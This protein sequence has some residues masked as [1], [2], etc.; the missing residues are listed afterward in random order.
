MFLQL[1][2]EIK[3]E[4]YE[5]NINTHIEN[6]KSFVRPIIRHLKTISK[7]SKQVKLN[8]RQDDKQSK[9]NGSS[10]RD[11]ADLSWTKLEKDQNTACQESTY[12]KS[13]IF[14]CSGDW[15]RAA[16]SDSDEKIQQWRSETGG[17]LNSF[18]KNKVS[19][20]IL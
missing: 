8:Y 17:D 18:L 12:V 16:K 4:R 6:P 9:K 19:N 11:K 1:E 3:T 14:I 20:K 10:S 2:S 13:D 5:N 7:I 15:N